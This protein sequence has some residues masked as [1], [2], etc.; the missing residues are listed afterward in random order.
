MRMLQGMGYSRVIRPAASHSPIDL[1]ASNGPE[2]L[3]VQCNVGGYMS[4]EEEAVPV[5]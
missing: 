5:E 2:T 4:L 3:A 1:L